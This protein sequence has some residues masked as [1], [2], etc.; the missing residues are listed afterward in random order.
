PAF[1]LLM[2]AIGEWTV[3]YAMEVVSP[4]LSSKL[5]FDQLEYLGIVATPVAALAFSLQYTARGHWLSTARLA[6]L[7]VVPITTL[8]L[9]WTNPT[10]GPVQ[11]AVDM[12]SRGAYPALVISHGPWFWIHVA[13][14][15]TLLAAAVALIIASLLRSPR[16][17]R[18]QI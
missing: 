8:V 18:G 17:Y 4:D 16:Q 11:S 13:Y 12:D 10:Y 3:T 9:L 6:I 7:A 14:S 2:A 5:L 1:A 15:Y